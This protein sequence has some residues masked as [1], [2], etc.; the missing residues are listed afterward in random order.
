MTYLLIYR[1]LWEH[2]PFQTAA[3][4]QNT[5][6]TTLKKIDGGPGRPVLAVNHHS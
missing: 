1:F 3:L 6:K 4:V 5:D 2:L